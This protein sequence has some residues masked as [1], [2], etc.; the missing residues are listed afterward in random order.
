MKNLLYIFLLSMLCLPLTLSAQW[1]D[2][3]SGIASP[4][5]GAGPNWDRYHVIGLQLI[6]SD[7]LIAIANDNLVD[8]TTGIRVLL[9]TYNGGDSWLADTISS[10][11]NFST[12]HLCHRG[13]DNIW[14]ALNSSG[15]T[16]SLGAKIYHSADSGATWTEQFG[17]F[18]GNNYNI[19]LLHFF[20]DTVGMAVGNYRPLSTTDSMGIF[21]TTNGGTTW[22]EVANSQIPTREPNEFNIPGSG[23]NGFDT[24]GDTLW[25]ATWVPG[26][27]WRTTD[28]GASWTAD[29]TGVPYL[30]SVQFSD[31]L[32]GIAVA[33]FVPGLTQ[34]D[35]G[36]GARTSDGGK[37]WI[38]F[39]TPFWAG[40]AEYIPGSDS[41]YLLSYRYL[42]EGRL[43][44]THNSGKNWEEFH[45]SY[46]LPAHSMVLTSATDG[47]IGSNISSRPDLGGIYRWRG[48]FNTPVTNCFDCN[49]IIT[50][51]PYLESFEGITP[52]DWCQKTNEDMDWTLNYEGTQFGGSGPDSAQD[53]DYYIFTPGWPYRY[54]NKRA[55]I[56]TPCFA[57]DSSCIGGATLTF[58]YHMY[59]PG[60]DHLVVFPSTDGGKIWQTGIW[61]RSS[62]QGNSW[63][64]VTLDISAYLGDTVRFLFRAQ[65]DGASCHF[66]LDNVQV[67][68]TPKMQLA[69]TITDPLCAGDSS[70]QISVNMSTGTA[71]Y[72]YQWTN[73]DTVAN[74]TALTAGT[75]GVT[76]Q[77][78]NGCEIRDSVS[79][80]SPPAISFSPSIV[81]VTCN[82]FNNGRATVTA[83]GGTGTLQYNWSTGDTVNQLTNLSPGNYTLIIT[84]QNGCTKTDSF[85]ITEPLPLLANPL[86]QDVSCKGDSNGSI[87][88]MPSGGNPPYSVTWAGGVTGFSLTN[89]APGRQNYILT[90]RK[91]CFQGGGEN[92]SEPD[93]LLADFTAEDVQCFGQQDGMLKANPQGGTQPYSYL[94]SNGDT[95]DSISMLDVG[96]YSLQIKDANGCSWEDSTSL[97]QPDSLTGS[98]SAYHLRCF[99]GDDGALRALVIG[100]NGGYTYQWSSG[101][102][103]DS[104]SG[105]SAG[106]YSVRVTDDKGCFW[107][108]S[109]TL[110]QPPALIADFDST[111]ETS[112]GA[113]DATIDLT[114]NGGTP[115]YSFLWSNGKTTQNLDSLATNRFYTVTI[116]DANG[117]ILQDSVLLG[118]ITGLAEMLEKI[119][120][121]LYPN[122]ARDKLF[123]SYDAHQSGGV[124]ISIVDLSGKVLM[125]KQIPGQ[126]GTTTLEISIAGLPKGMYF[127]M[128]QGEKTEAQVKWIKQ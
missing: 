114:V 113:M 3:G 27:V 53:G 17:A 38:P 33:G 115:P 67:H 71:P 73:G 90:D 13:M 88:L 89:L 117:C 79:V 9:K 47:Y 20:N 112:A 116:S 125:S 95:T 97:S 107:E 30:N 43:A 101:G 99:G 69:A 24:R 92:V 59:G 14:V 78:A 111:D 52:N 5:I 124:Q 72:Q 39:Q 94:W 57:L 96:T 91:N 100:G 8:P 31:P 35:M 75:Y 23:N 50:E 55:N 46:P 4:G 121:R 80:G 58:Y 32:H 118:E 70:G 22:T 49:H 68:I 41:S 93:S 85:L 48:D 103:T 45:Y 83:R 76:I 56:A 6:S 84:D 77:D 61:S 16:S 25:F 122:P 29:T 66:G 10:D 108:D 102:S 37:T 19:S 109:T 54:P 86:I 105:L 98:I 63:R 21:R 87:T 36:R 64:K 104:L 60:I 42:Q 82:G 62:N 74:P 26:R 12:N 120:F 18:N 11:T 40:Y 106:A 2:L 81:A 126:L 34:T 127:L 65:N 28:Q 119:S 15:L 1:Q 128:M 44:I 51:F 7:T 123:I 110:T